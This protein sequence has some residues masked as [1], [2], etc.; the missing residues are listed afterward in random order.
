MRAGWALAVFV[1][2]CAH[3]VHAQFGSL[4]LS[5][6]ARGS[7]TTSSKLFYNPDSPSP[8]IRAQHVPFEDIFGWGVEV[9]L[10]PA[11][12]SYFLTLAVDILSK[13]VRQNQLVALTTPPQVLP[14]V[15]GIVAIPIEIGLNTFVPTGS[16]SFRLFMGGGIG[17]YA[18]ERILEVA[19]V[20]ATRGGRPLALGIHV[21]SGV[22]YRIIDRISARFDIRF[23]DPEI[24]TLN[25]FERQS[26]VF[27]GRL[28]TFPTG[29]M[30]T[31][32]NLD[33]L[34]FGAAL[35]VDIL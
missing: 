21:Q 27:N 15:E 26:S 14:M 18:G 8:T 7:Y 1:S 22:E 9:R 29:T 35:V 24:P 25:R 20:R 6:T 17:V 32:I 33:G 28:L 23:R 10:R 4:Q 16:E 2:L 34:N 12:D 13:T 19:G 3:P 11:Q 31:Q 5:L 30:K